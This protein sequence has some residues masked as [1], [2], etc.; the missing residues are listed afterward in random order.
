MVSIYM[1]VYKSTHRHIVWQETLFNAQLSEAA[2]LVVDWPNHG[3]RVDV[4][5][6]A[7]RAMGSL[8]VAHAQRIAHILQVAAVHVPG[9][10]AVVSGWNQGQFPQDVQEW[11]DIQ[12]RIGLLQGAPLARGSMTLAHTPQIVRILAAVHFQ[13]NGVV[14]PDTHISS[15]SGY[16]IHAN[17]YKYMHIRANR[18][19]IH[20]NT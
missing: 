20:A 8:T 19:R 12:D 6:G 15:F 4:E 9:N 11:H 3:P 7:P 1:Y 2:L 14:V 18:Y 5:E 10:G 16:G 13:G 17:M